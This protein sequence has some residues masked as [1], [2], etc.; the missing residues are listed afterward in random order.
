MAVFNPANPVVVGL[1]TKKDHF[2]RGFNNGL[3]LQEGSVG[4]VKV[5]LSGYASDPAVAGADEA[6]IAYNTTSGEVRV[7]RNTSPFEPLGTAPN[8]ASAIFAGRLF[9]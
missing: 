8:D 1:P 2:D 7:S 4:L 3:A 5:R 9:G 6:V